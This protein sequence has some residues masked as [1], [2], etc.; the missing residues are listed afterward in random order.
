MESGDSALRKKSGLTRF[1]PH[2]AVLVFCLGI[3]SL[4]TQQVRDATARYAIL[5]GLGV[6]MKKNELRRLRAKCE[7]SPNCPWTLY[8]SKEKK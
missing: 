6:V 3:V 8:M 1:D 2:S 4:N 7:G 5:K